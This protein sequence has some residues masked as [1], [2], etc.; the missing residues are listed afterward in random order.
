MRAV[1]SYVLDTHALVFALTAPT[2][3]GRRARAALKRVESSRDEAWVPAAVIAEVILLRELGRIDVG[4]PELRSALEE[5]AN[6]RF[7]SL[8][9]AQLDLFRELSTVRDPFDRLIVSAAK[10][11]GAKLVSKD[12]HL[13]ESGL[14]EVI[15]K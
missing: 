6:V 11:T 2:K 1:A 8:D 15:W 3:L 9:L 4:F 14:V 10:C 7:L 5:R 12:E 13:A